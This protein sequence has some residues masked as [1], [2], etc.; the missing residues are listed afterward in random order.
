MPRPY[1]TLLAGCGSISAAWLTDLRD[2]FSARVEI[3]GLVDLHIETAKKRAAEFDLA[4]A[5]TG[6]LL[7]EAL[8]ELQ[9]DVMFNCTIPEAHASTCATALRG[10]CHVLVEKPLAGTVAE[11][12]SL[13]AIAAETGKCLAVIQNR[14]YLA[15][16]IAARRALAGGVIGR[17]HSLYADFFLAPRFGGFRE[18]IA[19]PLLLDMAIHTFDQ[20]RFLTGLNATRATCHEFNPSGS[21]FAHGASAIATFWR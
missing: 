1:R 15:G 13:I 6:T 8:A 4:G 5:W 19:H 12:Q 21:W 10:G 2:H 9:P 14:R 17:V 3:V 7:D 18:A 20:G 16:A 11:A